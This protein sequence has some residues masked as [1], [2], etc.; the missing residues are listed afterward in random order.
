MASSY[1]IEDPKFSF[2][3]ELGLEKLN[4]GVYNGSWCGSGE[5]FKSIDP[6]TGSVIAEVQTGTLDELENCMKIGVESYE[7]WKNLPAPFRGE[8]VRQIGDELRKYREP[9]GKKNLNI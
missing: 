9:L 1:L 3:R 5:I 2:L 7:Q 4:K 6:A 8:I